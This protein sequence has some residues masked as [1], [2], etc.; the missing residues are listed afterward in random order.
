MIA[1]SLDAY[2]L[3]KLLLEKQAR[4]YAIVARELEM[5]ASEC[6][7]AVQRLGAAGLVALETRRPRAKAV[8]DFLFAGL[9]YVFPAVPGS[10]QLGLATSYA[11]NPLHDLIVADGNPIPVWPDAEGKVRGY[12]IEPL[13]PSAPRAARQ[14]PEFTRCLP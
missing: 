7:A 9:R 5:S 10:L 2:V 4:P 8:E 3:A 13:H 1:K 14:N 11:A 12:A 6:H